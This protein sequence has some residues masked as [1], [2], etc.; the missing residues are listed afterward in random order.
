MGLF[1]RLK[2]GVGLIYYKL[3]RI[4]RIA[5]LRLFYRLRIMKSEKTIRYIIENQ[6]SVARYG[7]GEFGILL[8]DSAPGFQQKTP[9]LAQKL[10]A[11]LGNRNP[12]LL[13][14]VPWCLNHLKYRKADSKKWWTDWGLCNERQKRLVKIIRELSGA[15]YVFGDASITRPYISMKTSDRADIIFPL[16]KQIW[17]KRDLLIV[18]GEYTRLG[19]ANDL[20][21]NANSIKRVLVPAKDA[22]ACYEDIVS[23]IKS[24]YLSNQLVLLA[25][26]P[27]ATV[28]AFDL[29]KNDI[30]AIDIGHIDLEYDWYRKNARERIAIPGKYVNEISGGNIVEDCDDEKYL[31]QIIYTIKK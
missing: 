29:S 26:G 18:E 23:T 9:E 6:C 8:Q 10:K 4:I 19:V 28:L 27:T 7:D 16:L 30:Q 31:S 15:D 12:N 14:C 11:A 21:S 3:V 22:F 25:V 24:V 1:R 17:D 2:I 5:E 13:L 20:F